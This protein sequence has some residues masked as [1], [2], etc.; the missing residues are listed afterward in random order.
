MINQNNQG[1]EN[2]NFNN[3]IEEEQNKKKN[4]HNIAAI[5]LS[6]FALLAAIV[7]V[8]FAAYTWTFTSTKT[9]SLSTGSISLQLL[10]ST[11]QVIAINNFLPMSD[12][13][14]KALTGAGNKFD[15]AVT[16]TTGAAGTMNYVINVTK[17]SADSGYNLLTNDQVKFYLTS[18]SGTTETPILSETLASTVLGSSG[19]TGNLATGLKHTHGAAGSM[20]TNYRFRMWVAGT[21]DASSWTA[22]SKLQYKVKLGV[23]GSL[24]A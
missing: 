5:G 12:A 4:S 6:V 11:D 20:T 7:G 9:N 17:L 16:S 23:T 22:S 15:F 8:S 24:G 3:F 14:G 21:T 10:E 19:T 13:N 18:F 1:F 2:N